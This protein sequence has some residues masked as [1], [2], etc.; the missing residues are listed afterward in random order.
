M[1]DQ[2]IAPTARRILGT[3]NSRAAQNAIEEIDVLEANLR[4]SIA[5]IL[6]MQQ[7]DVDSG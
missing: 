2:T 1:T 5:T 7:K 6:M 3:L 4:G